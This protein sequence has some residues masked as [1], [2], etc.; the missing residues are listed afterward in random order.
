MK[1]SKMQVSIIHLELNIHEFKLK[2]KKTDYD[3]FIINHI[4]L[5]N[6]NNALIFG[7]FLG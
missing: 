1:N 7:L 6:I 2:A 3:N 4:K 5:K